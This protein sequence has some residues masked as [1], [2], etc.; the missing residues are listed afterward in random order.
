[1]V[2]ALEGCVKDAKSKAEGDSIKQEI[3]TLQERADGLRRQV[4][5][6]PAKPVFRRFRSLPTPGASVPSSITLGEDI[7]ASG[8]ACAKFG[9]HCRNGQMEWAAQMVRALEGCVKD[10]KSKEEGDSIKQEIATLQERADGLRR[11]VSSPPAKPVF[12]R[13]RSLPTPGASV[14]SSITLGE[15]ITASGAAC[16]KFGEHSRNGQMEWAAQ[17][18]RALEGCVKDAKSK[19]EGDSIKRE[20]ATL[21][22]R[23]DG[24]RRQVSRPPSSIA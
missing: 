9:E 6:P 10:A 17:M 2:R 23:A 18:V 7:T 21:Q 20:I 14:P 4:S 1:M 22:E 5:S 19:G 13:F 24:L 3:A 12:R 15:D 8:A 16:A 11:Q